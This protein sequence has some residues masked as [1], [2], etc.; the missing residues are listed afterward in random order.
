[1][2]KAWLPLQILC[3]QPFHIPVYRK[4]RLRLEEALSED[5]RSRPAMEACIERLPG[6]CHICPFTPGQRQNRKALQVATGQDS[7]DL[8]KR[9]SKSNRKSKRSIILQ[10]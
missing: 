6:K 1:M 2:V 4:K 5:R 7:K 8:C 10:G 9:R 3:R